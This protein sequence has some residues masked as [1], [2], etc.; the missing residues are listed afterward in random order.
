MKPI[1]P[2]IEQALS[3]LG[4]KGKAEE[5]KYLDRLDLEQNEIEKQGLWEYFVEILKKGLKYENENHLL[6]AYL[7]GICPED[8]LLE[9]RDL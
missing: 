4:E 6:V 1:H 7:W 3:S 9:E 5:R 2:L 8:P